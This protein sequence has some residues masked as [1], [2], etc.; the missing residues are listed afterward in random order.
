MG[1]T[2]IGNS[3]EGGIWDPIALKWVQPGTSTAA[4]AAAAAGR[5]QN[6]NIGPRGDV[7]QSG[8]RVDVDA[9]GGRGEDV[10]AKGNPIR[11][12][13]GL[14]R[15]VQRYQSLAAPSH[16]SGPEIHRGRSNATRGIGMG[17]L[18][19][20]RSR[21]EGGPTPAR[22]LLRAQTTGA[23][24]AVQSGAASIR[25]GPMARA[26]AARGAVAQGARVQ[27]QGNQDAYALQAREM[28]DGASQYFG[29]ASAQRGADLGLATDQAKLHAGQR[30]A[31]EGRDQFYEN[32]GFSTKKAAADNELGRSSSDEAA[33][34]AGRA[35]ALTE[36][37]TATQQTQQQVGMG[38]G[39]FTGAIGAAQKT[40]PATSSPQ[41]KAGN[42]SDPWDPSNYSG[43]DS[44]TKTAVRDLSPSG[45]ATK[46]NMQRPGKMSDAEAARLQKQGGGMLETI[47]AQR[48][49]EGLS[50][51][52]TE[53]NKSAAHGEVEKPRERLRKRAD[54]IIRENP[55]GDPKGY[56]RSMFARSTDK[57]TAPN[58]EALHAGIEKQLATDAKPSYGYFDEADGGSRKGGHAASRKGQ[59]GYMFGGAPGASWRDRLYGRDDFAGTGTEDRA[60]KDDKPWG[61]GLQGRRDIAMSD[62]KAK[63][64]AYALG[65]AHGQ[66][67]DVDAPT[68]KTVVRDAN[69]V[70]NRP[71]DRLA[72]GAKD[73]V[74]K[75]MSKANDLNTRAWDS[76]TGA[77]DSGG[78][79]LH[80]ALPKSVVD[81]NSKMWDSATG[82]KRDTA[83]SDPRA[84]EEARLKG[85]QQGLEAASGSSAPRLRGESFGGKASNS[86]SRASPTYQ[87]KMV[88][89]LSDSRLEEAKKGIDNSEGTDAWRAN[90]QRRAAGGKPETSPPGAAKVMTDDGLAR[91]R[92]KEADALTLGDRMT[93]PRT[94]PLP[95]AEMRRNPFYEAAPPA[96]AAAETLL[97]AGASIGQA[98][99]RDATGKERDE[100]EMTSDSR[101]KTGA[102][103]GGPMA[104]AN[105]S[106]VPSSYEYK[107]EF[108]PPEQEPGEENI[109]PMADKMKRDRV[110]G[111]AIVTDPDTKMLAIDK[112]K[113]LKLVMGGL[114][115]LQRQVDRMKKRA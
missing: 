27:A 30:S 92:R 19:M 49:K 50:T 46:T 88:K 94:R 97:G 55:Y 82:K 76:V 81:A 17:A 20:M 45:V 57:E 13:S 109:G 4:D 33:S 31:N 63:A 83:M 78:K 41:Q 56:D 104:S 79:A 9:W 95:G 68:A 64:E 71:L 60:A 6:G 51:V 69:K 70:A 39:T 37:Q 115:D 36:R 58:T 48:R 99:K 29:A 15:D 91:V 103:D 54:D 32:L 38:V 53:G 44:R 28:A 52:D 93:D 18:D 114:A 47:D 67:D 24:N 11:G 77:I 14:D 12:T 59:A 113:G 72:E 102:R 73:G 75:G 25:G 66:Q 35:Q 110:A 74:E 100:Y 89:D 112:T 98:I 96:P 90:R 2:I 107:S 62:P 84:K 40:A 65:R 8:G 16:A 80:D 42:P 101:T 106:M 23:V 108:T 85:V 86:A 3:N 61:Q 10:D 111:T 5:D 1:A 87:H 34:N 105:R 7:D 21:A 43:S 22:N 26:A